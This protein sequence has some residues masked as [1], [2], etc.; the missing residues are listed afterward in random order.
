MI[1]LGPNPTPEEQAA[2]DKSARREIEIQATE[3]LLGAD[4]ARMAADG[5]T[6][7]EIAA[8]IGK[9]RKGVTF[10]TGTAQKYGR[11]IQIDS[12]IVPV[13]GRRVWLPVQ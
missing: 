9:A 12:V 3:A 2:F 10:Y 1:I 8:E 13:K 5:M 4:V 11:T 7:A 6:T